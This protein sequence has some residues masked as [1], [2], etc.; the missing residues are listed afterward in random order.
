MN[1]LA[2][3]LNGVLWSGQPLLFCTWNQFQNGNQF[4]LNS[5]ITGLFMRMRHLTVTRIAIY[6]IANPLS[7][8]IYSLVYTGILIRF[9]I[10]VNV[11]CPDWNLDSRSIGRLESEV[12]SIRIRIPGL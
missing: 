4:V 5:V 11:F 6:Y 1:L 7:S 3:P 8:I 2:T 10:C 9:A 12:I